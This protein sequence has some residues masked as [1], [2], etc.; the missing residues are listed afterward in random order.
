[1]VADYVIKAERREGYRTGKCRQGDQSMAWSE[2]NCVYLCLQHWGVPSVAFFSCG[3]FGWNNEIDDEVMMY[4]GLFWRG[5]RFQ[6]CASADLGFGLCT[7]GAAVAMDDRCLSWAGPAAKITSCL[8]MCINEASCSD[9][10]QHLFMLHV[11]FTTLSDGYDT[12]EM[13]VCWS[14]AVMP[15]WQDLITWR[16]L[17]RPSTAV[18]AAEIGLYV[19]TVA[20]YML[21]S[22]VLLNC[23][24]HE[25]GGARY[26]LVHHA[27]SCWSSGLS[28][29]ALL[30]RNLLFCSCQCLSFAT[31]LLSCAWQLAVCPSSKSARRKPCS[32]P[33]VP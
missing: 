22:T 28:L 18:V 33:L 14:S 25:T 23:Y 17:A 31:G 6:K 24:V 27:Y 15:S 8:H 16:V 3:V 26:S 7:I 10:L 29:E 4:L 1:M 19:C 21:Y 5:P 13:I 2:W 30:W 20:W 32:R 12:S 11:V 9:Q